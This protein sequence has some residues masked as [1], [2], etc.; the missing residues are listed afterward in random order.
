MKR[1]GNAAC[2]P[3]HDPEKASRFVRN[4]ERCFLYGRFIG[5]VQGLESAR[6]KQ[7]IQ[8]VYRSVAA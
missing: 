7:V 5:N 2:N 1:A 6:M 3:R 8:V 4:P